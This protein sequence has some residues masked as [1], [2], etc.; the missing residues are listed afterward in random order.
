MTLSQFIDKFQNVRTTLL[1]YI[2]FAIAG[3]SV[4]QSLLQGEPINWEIVGGGGMLGL[5]GVNSRDGSH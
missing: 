3:L 4:L 2:G 1:G 5:L